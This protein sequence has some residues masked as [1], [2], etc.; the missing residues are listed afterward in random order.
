MTAAGEAELKR[1]ARLRTLA[2]GMCQG[3]QGNKFISA[4]RLKE[5]AFIFNAGLLFIEFSAEADARAELQL[6]VA[7]RASPFRRQRP[8]R[9][10]PRQWTSATSCTAALDE[11][12][13]AAPGK[14]HAAALRG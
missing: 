4:H 12:R 9:P 11:A 14:R 5:G 2:L 6:K 7:P 8:R 13:A 3:L 1:R 10:G